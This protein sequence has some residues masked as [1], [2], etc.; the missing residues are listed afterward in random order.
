[1]RA[2]VY[3]P[4]LTPVEP[5][6]ARYSAPTGPGPG[7]T[8]GRVLS[9]AAADLRDLT[10]VHAAIR[11]FTDDTAGRGRALRDQAA[12]TGVVDDH[13]GLQGAAAVAAQPQALGDLARIRDA[14]QAA[15]GT[16]AMAAAYDAQI[17]PAIA[18][19]A[20][21]ITGHAL[22]QAMVERQ[23]LTDQTMQTAQ[24]DAALAWHDPGRFV[25]GLGA[26]QT[27]AAAQAGPMASETD[28]VAAM[29]G[30]VGGA[31]AQAIGE[32]LAAR[33]PEFAAH[34]VDGWGD[35]LSP[36]AYQLAVARIGQGAREHQ[37]ATIFAQAA[38]GNRASDPS[39]SVQSADATAI[40][41]PPG[42]AVHPIAGGTVAAI[43]GTP[44]N[45]SIRIVH[46][47]G[48]NTEYGGI[49]LAAVAPGDLVSP[50]HVI[51]SAGPVVTL[52]A[53][54]P[55]GQPADA[56]ALLDNAGGAGA[57]IGTTDTPRAWDLPT[58][59][60]RIAARQ[61]LPDQ[62][63]ALAASLGQRRMLSD[64]AQLAA[65]DQAAGRTIATMAAAAPASF[66]QGA[67]LPIDLA[68]R[69][70]PANFANV[71]NA[72][73]NAAQSAAVPGP[74]NATALRLELLQR[75]SPDQFVQTNLAP[76][77]GAVH[78][79]DLAR[80]AQSQSAMAAGQTADDPG[81]HRAAVLDALARHEFMT[82]EALPDAI[83]PTVSNQATTLLRLNQTD[84][85]DRPAI[86]AAVADAIQNRRDQS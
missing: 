52:Q 61:D 46:P 67:D 59:I 10:G 3:K 62:D 78:T 74:G 26:V 40:Y 9:A 53:T 36:A 50:Q 43:A 73:R 47:D 66:A 30:A 28:R 75:R 64:S 15:L 6:H 25:Q 20:A 72:L 24:R 16:P 17:G 49:G 82:G 84:P 65:N 8:I 77:I 80:L 1:M 29:R 54:T 34:I 18:D 27:L 2:P 45:A 12:V 7:A 32:A 86:D 57:M 56:A 39:A 81:D 60:E 70:T 48:S 41:A 19:A 85:G 37:M 76:L 58:M 11:S 23:A 14:G 79:D 51:G 21:R 33:E 4:A 22:N 35:A 5:Y 63:R 13:A 68:A 38:G 83:L 31:V 42:A 44:D 71:D 55:T 69:L